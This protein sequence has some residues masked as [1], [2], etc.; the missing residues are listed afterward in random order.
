MTSYYYCHCIRYGI[1]VH[2]VHLGMTKNFNLAVVKSDNFP[3]SSPV[4]LYMYTIASIKFGESA[5]CSSWQ[6]LVCH[7]RACIRL[8]WR[9]FNSAIYMYTKFTKFKTSTKSFQLYGRLCITHAPWF[10]GLHAIEYIYSTCIGVE[11]YLLVFIAGVTNARE[12]TD[13]FCGE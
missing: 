2:K 13:W 10:H 11:R 1:T 9:V 6:S 3:Q 7:R 8:N 4:L 12:S 5:L